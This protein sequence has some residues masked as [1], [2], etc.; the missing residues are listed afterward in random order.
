MD[1]VSCNFNTYYTPVLI[2]YG[3]VCGNARLNFL[4][5]K[6]QQQQFLPNFFGTVLYNFCTHFCARRNFS[7]PKSR[8]FRIHATIHQIRC[9]WPLPVHHWNWLLS[10]RPSAVSDCQAHARVVRLCDTVHIGRRCMPW[11]PLLVLINGHL[12][13][14]SKHVRSWMSHAF[15][16][17]WRVLVI[18]V[19]LFC[20]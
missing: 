6:Q 10:V 14:Y 18:S 1:R 2:E 16:C 12:V 13:Y 9:A 7:W 19:I 4:A 20:K 3:C 17:K 8:E 15:T 11:M 5:T